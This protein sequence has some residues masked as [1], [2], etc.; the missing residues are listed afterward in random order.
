MTH[1]ILQMQLY[2]WHF[3]FLLSNGY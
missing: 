1:V 3:L 2:W